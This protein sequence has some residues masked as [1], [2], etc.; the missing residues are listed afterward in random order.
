MAAA[1][2]ESM[3]IGGMLWFTDLT[4]PDPYYLLPIAA[5]LTFMANIEV[6]LLWQY[7][8]IVIIVDSAD[9]LDGR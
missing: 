5:C 3:K 6:L 1:P 9:C 7:I 2:I 8:H 4:L